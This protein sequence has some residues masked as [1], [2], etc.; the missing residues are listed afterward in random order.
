MKAAAA[1]AL[2]AA[3]AGCSRGE[4]PEAGERR[5]AAAGAP[6]DARSQRDL[7]MEIADAENLRKD[8]QDARYGA[9]RKSWLG[10]RVTWKLDVMPAL[11]RAADACHALPFDRLG[12]DRDVV[13]GWMP[14]L[15]LD[16]AGFAALEAR[17][18]GLARCPVTVEA[19][20]AELTLSVDEPTSLTL[21]DVRIQAAR[22]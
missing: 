15:R 6:A 10:R 7:A 19:T 12:A 4:E 22:L 14:R 8:E 21:A 13:Q 17:C 1:L 18:A 11:C 20:V 3:L 9:I 2:L 5:P 16:P